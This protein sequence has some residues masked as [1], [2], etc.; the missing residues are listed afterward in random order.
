[1][2]WLQRAAPRQLGAPRHAAGDANSIPAAESA[3]GPSSCPRSSTRMRSQHHPSIGTGTILLTGPLGASASFGTPR[4]HILLLGSP[5]RVER[6]SSNGDALPRTVL[7]V[8]GF[9]PDRSDVRRHHGPLRR[10]VAALLLRVVD[11]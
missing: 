4:G 3:A 10:L 7:G 1:M 5:S 6:T 8:E 2:R 9:D 11:L